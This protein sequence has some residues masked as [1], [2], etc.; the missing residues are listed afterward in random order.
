MI[1]IKDYKSTATQK[2]RIY[3]TTPALR[4]RGLSL[5]RRPEFCGMT[6]QIITFIV[7]TVYFHAKN[8]SFVIEK[9]TQHNGPSHDQLSTLDEQLSR[10]L[11]Q[12]ASF[13]QRDTV[14]TCSVMP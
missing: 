4:V 12:A 10:F 1:A 9:M 8:A 2:R 11:E 13:F 3:R 7:S 5:H 6:I 14:Q